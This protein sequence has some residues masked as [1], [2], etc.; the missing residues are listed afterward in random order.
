MSSPRRLQVL[1]LLLASALLCGGAAKAAPKAD[2][3]LRIGLTHTQRSLDPWQDR[4]AV[5]AGRSLLTSL[6]GTFQ[7]QHLMGWGAES[8]Q[9]SP[10]RYDWRSLDRRIELVRRTRGTPVITLC[11]SPDWMKGGRP[12][13]TDWGRL[14]VAPSPRHY[15]DFAAMAAAVARRYPD[16]KHFQVWNE[17]KGFWNVRENRWDHEAYTALYDEVFRAL[18]AVDPSIQVGGPYVSMTSWYPGVGGGRNSDVRGPWGMVDQR[19]LDAVS[20]WLD[21][22][23]GADFVVVDGPASLR[24]GSFLVPPVESVE[25][26]V[27]VNRWLRARTDLPIWWGEAYP[28]PFG[29]SSRLREAEEAE[30]WKATAEAMERSGASVALFWQPES[31]SEA[32]GLW[33]ATSSRSGGRPTA[34]LA[35]LRPWLR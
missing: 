34:L 18:K 24:D 6:P 5:E 19:A 27:A 21:H 35:A 12:G 14:E 20:Y 29:T 3:P 31:T 25:K 8:P 30:L 15:D 10:G 23:E 17:M 13:A 9:P 22:A 1:G 7:N 2:P 11:C 4:R 26:F 33:T 16:V 32:R 28:I